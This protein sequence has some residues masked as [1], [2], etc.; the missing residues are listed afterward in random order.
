MINELLKKARDKDKL[1]TDKIF[2]EFLKEF[3]RRP[4]LFI[5][6]S[7]LL[8]DIDDFSQNLPN[9]ETEINPWISTYNQLMEGPLK[10]SLFLLLQ[11]ELFLSD[12]KYSYLDI[13]K[14]S[15]GGIL[16]QIK[17]PLIQ[18]HYRNAIAHQN[19]YYTEESDINEKRIILYDWDRKYDLSMDEF[20]GEFKKLTKFILTFYLNLLKIY[21]EREVERKNFFNRNSDVFI[22]NITDLI[23]DKIKMIIS[24]SYEE[25]QIQGRFKN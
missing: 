5:F 13:R 2:S 3:L 23:K 19:I 25:F 17:T 8:L 4:H 14:S 22:K 11:L 21:F 10:H 7:N 15:L 16:R 9:F 20:F 6:I 12:K 24:L 18:R 1:E